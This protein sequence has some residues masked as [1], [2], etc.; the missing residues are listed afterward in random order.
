M[1]LPGKLIVVARIKMMN[2]V[3]LYSNMSYHVLNK[4]NSVDRIPTFETQ[5]FD[6]YLAG[7]DSEP[8]TPRF[9]VTKS[10]G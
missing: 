10:D 2:L 4:S 1:E 7:T 8:A 9:E 6:P 5:L 3:L